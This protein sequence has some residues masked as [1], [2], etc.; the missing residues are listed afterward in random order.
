MFKRTTP[1]ITEDVEEKEKEKKEET[2]KKKDQTKIE[3]GGRP[4]IT[5]K[6]KFFKWYQQIIMEGQELAFTKEELSTIIKTCHDWMKSH[7]RAIGK[8]PDFNDNAKHY[9]MA[10]EIVEKIKKFRNEKEKVKS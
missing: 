5:Q 9:N 4:R 10:M 2:G 7:T 6:E 1:K 8:D 3:T